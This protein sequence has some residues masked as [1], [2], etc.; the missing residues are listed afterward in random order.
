LAGPLG[1]ARRAALKPRRTPQPPPNAREPLTCFGGKVCF[2]FLGA[3][4][5]RKIPQDPFPFPWPPFF[6][7][8]EPPTIVGKK[9]RKPSHIVAN[10]A[11]P[12]QSGSPSGAGL[13][14]LFGIF[15]HCR[16]T[17]VI[18]F[19]HQEQN[20]IESAFGFFCPP[21][22]SVRVPWWKIN[23]SDRFFC[24]SPIPF[25]ECRMIIARARHVPGGLPVPKKFRAA[26]FSGRQGLSQ[27]ETTTI[28]IPRC[29]AGFFVIGRIDSGATPLT[30]IGRKPLRGTALKNQPNHS[31]KLRSSPPALRSGGPAFFPLVSPALRVAATFRIPALFLIPST[32]QAAFVARFFRATRFPIAPPTGIVP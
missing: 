7:S 9:S 23:R 20:P 30:A 17:T 12:D 18:V 19:S 8:I 14:D 31:L 11:C 26:R 3:H 16:A 27:E 24:R 6:S 15:P 22:E 10:S 32:R 21:P 28:E 2:F 4:A 25:F 29:Q 13:T 5:R 1:P